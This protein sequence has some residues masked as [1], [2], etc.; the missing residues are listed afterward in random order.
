M[1]LNHDK[2]LL[3]LTDDVGRTPLLAINPRRVD[4]I[5]FLLDRGA[6]VHAATKRGTTPLMIACY[7]QNLESARLWLAAGVDIEARD[8]SQETALHSAAY[9]GYE[10]MRELVLEHNANI[11]ALDQNGNTPFDMACRF[12]FLIGIYGRKLTQDHGCLAFHE[13]LGNAEYTFIH[14]DK[15]HPPLKPL[16]QIRLP[17]G[18]LTLNYFRTL[19]SAID[20]NLIRNRDENGKLPIH[21]AC[22]NNAPVEVLAMLVENDAATLHIADNAGALPLHEICCGEVDDSSVRY[23]LEQGG[24]GTLTARTREGA[25]PL[26]VLCGSTNPSL[27]TVQY[28]VQSF[29]GSVTARTNAGQYPFV[30]AACDSSTASLSVVYELVRANPDLVNSN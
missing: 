19:L 26:H 23:L 21:I 15:F 29:P 28:V 10:E 16:Q 7:N 30:I 13:I 12:D 27:R 9:R 14:I 4:I 11:F 20:T 17:L 25:L 3:E 6:D 5:R 22:R 18:K 2:D 24:V 8:E 1:L